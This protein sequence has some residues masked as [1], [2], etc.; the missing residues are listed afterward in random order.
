MRNIEKL[1]GLPAP[2]LAPLKSNFRRSA[3]SRPGC[4]QLQLHAT[5]PRRP[6]LARAQD[7]LGKD[8]LLLARRELHHWQQH[9]LSQPPWE[10][11]L[12]VLIHAAPW[13]RQ[14][15]LCRAQRLHVCL[16]R[17]RRHLRFWPLRSA[18]L[19]RA[20]TGPLNNFFSTLARTW[21]H[22]VCDLFGW[23]PKKPL[24]K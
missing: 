15:N 14:T 7:H 9:S 11:Q 1:H 16:P 12:L 23:K 6:A 19:S 5:I 2:R 4:A 17:A 22:S 20:I 10:S 8:R 24:R 3:R 13:Q 21:C 18:K